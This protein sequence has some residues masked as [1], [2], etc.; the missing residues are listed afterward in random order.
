MPM[1]RNMTEVYD[2]KDPYS[3]NTMVAFY[4]GSPLH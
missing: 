3:V 2:I 4:Y 1:G